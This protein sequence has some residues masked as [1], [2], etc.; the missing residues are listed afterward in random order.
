MDD[1]FSLSAE[2]SMHEKKAAAK[3]ARKAARK[4]EATKPAYAYCESRKCV[5]IK[6]DKLSALCINSD[7]LHIFSTKFKNLV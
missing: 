4:V 1:V 2:E 5:I 7:S 6:E 3:A